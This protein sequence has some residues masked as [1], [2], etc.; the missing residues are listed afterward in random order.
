MNA[1]GEVRDGKTATCFCGKVRN[2]AGLPVFHSRGQAANFVL[3][4]T[5]I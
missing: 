2:S 1:L 4:F 5:S 3:A